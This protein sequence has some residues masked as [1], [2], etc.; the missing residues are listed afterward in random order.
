VWI[1]KRREVCCAAEEL[2]NSRTGHLQANVRDRHD[3]WT[4]T[5][6]GAQAPAARGRQSRERHSTRTGTS[7][8]NAH[9]DSSE[10]RLLG[11]VLQE[12]FSYLLMPGT[13]G[14]YIYTEA[15]W[16]SPDFIFNHQVT[17]PKHSDFKR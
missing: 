7:E 12:F 14:Q 16:I 10:T 2:L 8:R 3:T 5:G 15:E 17:K 4:T 6:I 13:S 11:D 9:G 1:K